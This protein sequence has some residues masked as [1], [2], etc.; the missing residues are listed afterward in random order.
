[1]PRNS[2]QVSTHSSKKMGNGKEMLHRPFLHRTSSFKIFS[3]LV[4]LASFFCTLLPFTHCFLPC[5][6]PCQLSTFPC[7]VTYFLN[8]MGNLN[9]SFIQL[10][11]QSYEQIFTSV[12]EQGVQWKRKDIW[13]M[14]L[15]RTYLNSEKSW[16]QLA[17]FQLT[18]TT[19]TIRT[20]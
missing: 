20:K 17:V 14:V 5:Y 7:F 13:K 2:C 12:G 8:K 18:L 11:K 19:E 1:M 6:L 10:A 3:C 4:H 16:I 15:K 9:S